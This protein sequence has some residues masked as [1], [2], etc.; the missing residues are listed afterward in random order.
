MISNFPPSRDLYQDIISNNLIKQFK[1]Y[2]YSFINIVNN[3]TQTSKTPKELFDEKGY[4]L[5]E[6]KTESELY[7][8]K[9]YY[10]PHELLCTF[11]GD[12]LK[13]KY[14]FFAI[15]KDINLINRDNQNPHR[16]DEY[17]SSVLCIQFDKGENNHVT[18]I[19]RYNHTIKN[20]NATYENNLDL[21]NAGLTYSFEKYYNLNIQNSGSKSFNIPGYIKAKDGKYY[22]YNYEI[23]N[24][25][26]CQ[27]NIIIDNGNPIKKYTDKSRY[28]IIDCYILNIQ[29]KKIF[30]YKNNTKI[31]KDSFINC[32]KNIDKITIINQKN[33]KIINIIM[34]NIIIKIKINQN[35]QII[36]YYNK[37]IEYIP[38]NFMMYNKTLK[39]IELPNTIKIGNMFLPTNNTL[40]NII[41]PKVIELG[42]YF[43]YDNTVRGIKHSTITNIKGSSLK[44]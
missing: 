39:K 41:I 4:I 1:N 34:H 38:D 26:Y 15:K 16:E 14:I 20:P 18:I 13:N 44:K 21:I 28:L 37:S 2:I 5:Y 43:L 31:S 9:N 32:F 19:S 7:T 12:R 24:I 6:C 10:K 33:E 40:T 42:D 27:N 17:G 11:K 29:E 3:N 23:D 35:N 8:Y 30:T 25:Y 22:E 36:E